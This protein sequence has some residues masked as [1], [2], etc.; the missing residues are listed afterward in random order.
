MRIRRTVLGRS[1][2]AD[3]V[4]ATI[5]NA[6]GGQP[7][8]T[9]RHCSRRKWL[10]RPVAVPVLK[11]GNLRAKPRVPSRNQLLTITEQTLALISRM[12]E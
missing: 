2:G 7:T 9:S 11:G 8:V 6:R 12:C 3:L 1:I 4:D 5:T 10:K